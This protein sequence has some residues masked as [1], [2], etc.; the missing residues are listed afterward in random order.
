VEGHRIKYILPATLTA[1]RNNNDWQKLLNDK[2]YGLMSTGKN[3]PNLEVLVL[4]VNPTKGNKND[5]DYI[6]GF[7]EKWFSE[8]GITKYK[9]YSSDL[10]AYTKTRIESFIKG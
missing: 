8:M 9:I 7:L 2:D 4:E 5:E 3:L 10:P 1:F 6:K